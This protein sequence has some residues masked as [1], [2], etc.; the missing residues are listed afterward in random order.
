ML[1]DGTMAE[2][3]LTTA[4]VDMITEV[5]NQDLQDSSLEPQA[6]PRLDLPARPGPYTQDTPQDDT[7]SGDPNLDALLARQASESTMSTGNLM[8]VQVSMA[9]PDASTVGL[10]LA[11]GDLDFSDVFGLR[12]RTPDLGNVSINTEVELLARAQ[13]MQVALHQAQSS[14]GS[15]TNTVSPVLEPPEGVSFGPWQELPVPETGSSPTQLALGSSTGPS[16]EGF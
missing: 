9:A 3:L 1:P 10:Q 11:V 8:D 15:Q 13:A 16:P 12:S 7:S 4:D 6:P 14:E 2:N 5:I